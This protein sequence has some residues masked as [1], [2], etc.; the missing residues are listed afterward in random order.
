M[1]VVDSSAFLAASMPDEQDPNAIAIVEFVQLKGAFV[2]SH[3]H[4]EVCN[5]LVTNLRRNRIGINDRRNILEALSILPLEVDTSGFNL[6]N[7]RTVAL[8]DQY[9]LT[10]YDAAYLELAQR[11]N[12]FLATFDTKLAAAAESLGLLHP[13]IAR[14]R[15]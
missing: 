10:A 15:L 11:E 1:I 7:G 8:A 3:F 14:A 9:N 2:P 5:A 6:A 13:A 12:I 4:I